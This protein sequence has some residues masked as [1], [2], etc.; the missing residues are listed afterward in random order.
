MCPTLSR[1]AKM[2]ICINNACKAELEDY[3]ERCP[4]C[5]R[6]Q[7]Q[8]DFEK[9]IDEQ[10]PSIETIHE[11]NWFITFWLWVIIVGNVLMAIISFFPKTMWGKNYPDDFVIP[12]IVPGLFCIINVI[13]A[14]IL[15]YWKK[16][17]FYLIALSAVIGGIFSFITVKSL[18]VGL[19]GLAL[20]WSIL[21]IKRNGISCWDVM[22]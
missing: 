3:V 7:K 9:Y 10:K 15:L 18:P 19:V 2:K 21:R 13:G 4:N 22:D 8:F 17:G 16:M 5:G 20:L 14:F 11:R 6:L 12:S 1:A